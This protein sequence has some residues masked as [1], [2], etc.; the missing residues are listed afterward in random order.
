MRTFRAILFAA[1]FLVLLVASTGCRAKGQHAA[2]VAAD[3]APNLVL[4]TNLGRIVMQLDRRKAPL[5]VEH[6]LAHVEAG[7][8]DS[9]VFHRVMRNSIIQTGRLHATGATRS[10]TA[11]PVPCE[12]HNGLLNVRGAVALARGPVVNGGAREFYINV[13]DN[14]AFDFQDTTAAAFGY[15]VFGRVIEGMEIVDRIAALPTAL[16]YGFANV[17]VTPAIIIRARVETSP[18]RADTG[19]RRA[20]T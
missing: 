2:A 9:L 17:P 11:E 3:S 7:F 14:P 13:R 4:E 6:I 12:A 16:R 19:G 15:A 5:T 20:A 10:S 18:T 8:Y 1:L